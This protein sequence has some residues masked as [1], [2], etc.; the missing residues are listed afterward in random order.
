MRLSVARAAEPSDGCVT[1]LP[2]TLVT[3]DVGPLLFSTTQG[4]ETFSLTASSAADT[5]RSS[6][7]DRYENKIQ[8][9]DRATYA[10]DQIPKRWGYPGQEFSGQPREKEPHP[11]GES[12][13]F[14]VAWSERKK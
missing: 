6:K 14:L 1:P 8:I 12:S 3:C 11:G 10:S 13:V 9:K 5:H 4:T 2:S 7:E